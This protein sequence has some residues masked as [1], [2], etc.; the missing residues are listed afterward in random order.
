MSIN[1]INEAI[2]ITT[3]SVESANSPAPVSYKLSVAME[4]I[5]EVLPFGESVFSVYDGT[6]FRIRYN[7]RWNAD[8]DEAV[9]C[10]L[11]AMPEVSIPVVALRLKA[12][13]LAE[14]ND[15]DED[16]L[17]A[18]LT[19]EYLLMALA[20]LEEVRLFGKESAKANTDSMQAMRAFQVNVVMKQLGIDY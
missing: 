18:N 13:A 9:P 14:V 3:V 4:A 19:S 16:S 15:L 6:H 5:Q 2:T 1:E 20:Y 17:Y 8:T 10:L 7:Y 11:H 12:R